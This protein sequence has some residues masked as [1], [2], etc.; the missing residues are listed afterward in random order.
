M[1]QKIVVS[2]INSFGGGVLSVVQDCLQEIMAIYGDKIEITAL[3]Y[4][5]SMIGVEGITYLEFPKARSNWYWRLYYEYIYFY[6]LSKILQPDIW[7]S[8]ADV[9]PRVIAPIQAV[10]CHNL[11]PFY[12]ITRQDARF[13]PVLAVYHYLFKYIYRINIR[14]N[15]FVIVQQQWLREEFE[16]MFRINNVLVAYPKVA[17]R[18]DEEQPKE[19]AP[20][21]GAPFT[22]FY[23]SVP[24]VFKNFELI[25]EAVRLLLFRNI[26]DFEVIFTFNGTE[27]NYAGRIRQNAEAIPQ[28]RFMGELSR[29]QVFAYHKKADV[30]LFSSKTE[31]WGMG[32]SEGMAFQKPILCID[33]SYARET[34]GNYKKAVFFPPN[35]PERLA[36]LM[37]DFIKNRPVF[38]AT[39]AFVPPPPF[40]KDWQHLFDYLAM[41]KP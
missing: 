40:A 23:P 3:V 39:T 17:A 15:K 25:T 9:T 10:Y 11:A 30:V 38:H 8:L 20:T 2:A 31:T 19:N 18:Y 41:N 6:R 32:I 4:N 27:N 29:K 13:D 34:V 14:K 28:L 1:K 33:T 22:F 21:T 5:K 35:K 12:Q 24:R 26:S 7:L 37:E 16:R 36:E